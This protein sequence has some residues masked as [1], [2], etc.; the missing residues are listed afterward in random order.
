MPAHRHV[1]AFGE[2]YGTIFNGRW[3]YFSDLPGQGSTRGNLD[4]DNRQIW[5]YNLRWWSV[6]A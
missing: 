1:S 2:A 6:K 5:L 3:G 4:N